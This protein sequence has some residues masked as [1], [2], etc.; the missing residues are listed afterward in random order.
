V[1]TWKDFETQ[2]GE[3]ERAAEVSKKM[4]NRVIKKRPIKNEDG[5]D[6][7]WEEYYDYIFPGEETSQANLKLLERARLW[8][9]QKS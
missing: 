5:E 6:A 1:E 2:L 3:H 9:K 7:G 4:P 8:K